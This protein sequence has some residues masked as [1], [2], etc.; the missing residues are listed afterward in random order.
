ML[1]PNTTTKFNQGVYNPVNP[2]KYKG[3]GSPVYR[4]GWELKFF[5]F[6]DINKNVLE[7]SSENTIIPYISPI[8]NKPHRYFVDNV[9]VIK[10]GE[11][12]KKYLIEI[13]P[14]M[15]TIPP[16]PSKK[17]KKSTMLYEQVT[18]AQNQAKWAAARVYAKKNG[19]EFMILTEKELGIKYGY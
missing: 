10:E 2:N 17:K 7:W 13:K 12:V 14:Y 6:C 4:S 18:Y 16:D 8:D 19:M 15:Q 11:K 3:K 5:K 1:P 9:V